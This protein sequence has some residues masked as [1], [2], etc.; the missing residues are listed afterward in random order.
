MYSYNI[1]YIGFGEMW[2]IWEMELNLKNLMELSKRGN[3]A[4]IAPP[5]TPLS[6]SSTAAPSLFLLIS[7]NQKRRRDWIVDEM[8]WCG[9]LLPSISIYSTL[10]FLLVLLFSSLLSFNQRSWLNER[11]RAK[12]SWLSCLAGYGPEA[13]SAEE[14]NQI[15]SLSFIDFLC[16]PWLIE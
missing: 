6:I 16:L 15:N 2:A 4:G 7:L 14:H 13:I 1:F 11:E 10:L 9:G 3:G 5:T 12:T 8:E